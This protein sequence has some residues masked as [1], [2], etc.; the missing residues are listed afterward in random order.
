MRCMLKP[1][2]FLQATLAA[3]RLLRTQHLVPCVT[4]ITVKLS[5]WSLPK[6][7]VLMAGT[8]NTE[9][10]WLPRFLM[11]K[12]ENPAVTLVGTERQKL[13]LEERDNIKLWSTLS[14]LCAG[15]CL[16][17]RTSTAESWHVWSAQSE[18]TLKICG[19]NNKHI[20]S[21]SMWRMIIQHIRN[22]LTLHG[23]AIC[24]RSSVCL[25]VCP[26]VI[27]WISQKQLKSG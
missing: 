9:V 1:T 7:D 12:T 18:E 6:H 14:K 16:V 21:I 15:H 5:L 22:K 27:W 13:L 4:W 25:S 11:W 20:Y 8:R 10:I 23:S 26:L 19:T 3:C 17:Q 2:S 24:C